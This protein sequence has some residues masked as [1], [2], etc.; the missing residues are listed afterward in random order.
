MIEIKITSREKARAKCDC[1]A[2]AA[3]MESNAEVQIGGELEE[4]KHEFIALLEVF[5]KHA[6]VAWLGKGSADAQKTNKKS[7][8]NVLVSK[9]PSGREL[10]P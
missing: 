4:I 9:A 7:A 3:L 5:E 2:D 10:S 6:I 1:G 8:Q